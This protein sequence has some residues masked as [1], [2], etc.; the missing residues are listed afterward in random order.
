V[1]ATRGGA[2]T[3]LLDLLTAAVETG[4]EA[5]LLCPANGP[6]AE[7]AANRGMPVEAVGGTVRVSHPA[8]FR[9][10]RRSLRRLSNEPGV[11]VL[12]NMTKAHLLAVSS[13]YATA[14]RTIAVQH[15]PRS[16][17]PLDALAW[18]LR[19]R[20]VLA[21][22]EA[23]RRLTPWPNRSILVPPAVDTAELGDIA[24]TTGSSAT[25]LVVMLGRFQQ[26]KGHLDFVEMAGRLR[27]EIP[28]ARFVILGADSEMEPD[29]REAV[30]GAIEQRGLAGVIDV[31][32]EL[33]LAELRRRVASCSVFV[34][35]AHREDFGIAVAEAM[36]MGRPVVSYN[37]VGPERLLGEGRGVT[38]TVGDVAAL[39]AAVRGVLADPTTARAR[40]DSARQFA[41]DTL[42]WN[43]L[44]PALDAIASLRR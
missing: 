13:G 1:I 24:R 10:L 28:A 21:S 9:D 6:L 36:A 11:I 32:G 25:P 26:Y 2:E 4:R 38:V 42:G 33:P 12:A 39:A 19:S 18:P 30:I 15:S 34:H 5:I 17:N 14:T 22:P 20:Y 8:S 29:F 3:Y 16:L 43:Q 27:S 35:P 44:L 7:D 31:P 41:M 40:A 37:T 23:G